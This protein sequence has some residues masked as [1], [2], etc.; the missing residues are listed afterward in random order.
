MCRKFLMLL[1]MIFLMVNCVQTNVVAETESAAQIKRL[2]DTASVKSNLT[3]QNGSAVCYGKGR[4][5]RTDVSTTVVAI[6]QYKISGENTWHVLNSWSSMGY[7]QANV[8]VNQHLSV[9]QG[10]EYRLYVRCVVRDDDGNMKCSPCQ[11][12]F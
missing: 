6:L 3:I 9:P 7:G 8:I 4:S 2:S 1:A 12:Q 5:F 11:V 10:Y